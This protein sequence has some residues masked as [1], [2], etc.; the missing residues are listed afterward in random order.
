MKQ[1]FLKYFFLLPL[2]CLSVISIAQQNDEVLW[3]QANDM[4]A[5]KDYAGALQNYQSIKNYQQNS[6][7][8]YNIGNVYYNTGKI[9]KAILSYKQSLRINP[10]NSN[11]INNL[12]LAEQKIENPIVSQQFVLSKWWNDFILSIHQNIWA[13]LSLLFAIGF[14]VAFYFSFKKET[15]QYRIIAFSSLALVVIC[16][17]GM[18]G[19]QNYW[20]ADNQAVAITNNELYYNDVDFKKSNEKVI[21]EGTIVDIIEQS[22]AYWK[23]Q[24]P[25]GVIA[26][27]YPRVFE[28]I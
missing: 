4:Y 1:L 16:I 10:N 17:I 15:K 9:G 13:V 23:V 11:A 25:N 8:L 5:Q 14:G 3:R 18:L 19:N 7:V 6:Q 24:L 26:Y 27:T 21:P 28:K 22:K 12:A 20:K 2:M